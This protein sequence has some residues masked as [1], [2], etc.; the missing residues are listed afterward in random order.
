MSLICVIE[1]VHAAE[2]QSR[3]TYSG[4]F[5]VHLQEPRFESKL[6]GLSAN[7]VRL[8]IRLFENPQYIALILGS[9]TY[10]DATFAEKLWT[11]FTLIKKNIKDFKI[12][13]YPIHVLINTS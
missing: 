3:S 1:T 6:R 10:Q 12:S 7:N 4:P 13:T 2:C 5:C 11:E 9:L 8:C